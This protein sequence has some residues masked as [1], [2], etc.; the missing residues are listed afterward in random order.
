MKRVLMIL[1]I[2]TSY[3]TIFAQSDQRK[4]IDTLI[5]K[6]RVQFKP[7][8]NV[9]PRAGD[10][11]LNPSNVLVSASPIQAPSMMALYGDFANINTS[12]IY[13]LPTNPYTLS[14]VIGPIAT[15][16]TTTPLIT[17]N[18]TGTYLLIAYVN[19]RLEDGAYTS[20]TT[21]R[22]RFQR[23]NNTP[24]SIGMEYL[25]YSG[26]LGNQTL[27]NQELQLWSPTLMSIY[28]TSNSND[29]ISIYG[30]VGNLPTYTGGLLQGRVIATQLV[31]TALRLK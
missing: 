18:G 26:V 11:W 20:N 5:V 13:E 12:T 7:F 6:L 27:A 4:T 19:V 25:G 2:I 21:I 31:F 24:S 10:L 17:L 29:G 30:N 1:C 3:Q 23:V 28:T 14:T 9:A 22:L 16:L 8:N 15:Q